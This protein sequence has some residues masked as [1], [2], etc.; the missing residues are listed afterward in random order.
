MTDNAL[1]A[2]GSLSSDHFVP[3]SDELNSL[4][5][6]RLTRYA[7]FLKVYGGSLCYD[8]A[9]EGGLRQKRLDQI[10]SFLLACGVESGTFTVNTGYA[11]GMGLAATEASAIREKTAGPGRTTL[12]TSDDWAVSPGV[13]ETAGLGQSV[14]D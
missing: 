14:A 10:E 12:I 1:L 3:R 13:K 11:G 6:R 4:G 2:E 5:V 8:G 9:D 7:E